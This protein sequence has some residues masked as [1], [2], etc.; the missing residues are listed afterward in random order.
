MSVID[1]WQLGQVVGLGLATTF[2][3]GWQ[4]Q[5]DCTMIVSFL[6]GLLV[7]CI[8]FLSVPPAF[9]E[10]GGLQKVQ[11]VTI[12]SLFYFYLFLL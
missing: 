11:R 7:S 3:Q 1:P 2:L 6:L 8:W 5:M 12:A 9:G 4:Y 10:A